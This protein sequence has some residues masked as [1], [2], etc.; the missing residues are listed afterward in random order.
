[1]GFQ[2]NV[3]EAH[4]SSEE[5]QYLLDQGRESGALDMVEHELIKNVFDFNERIVKNI[6]VPRTKIS[7][8]EMNCSGKDFIE[9][10]TKEGYSRIPIY[11]DNIDQIIGIVHAKDILPFIAN[12]KIGRASCR[13]KMIPYG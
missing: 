4:H 3:G 9:R 7:A 8:I 6:M 10:I 1:M 12:G 11:D 5:L 13:E 2:V